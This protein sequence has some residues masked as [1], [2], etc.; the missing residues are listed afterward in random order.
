MGDFDLQRL[1]EGMDL[2]LDDARER[3][4]KLEGRFDSL[5]AHRADVERRLGHVEQAVE[6]IQNEKAS[7]DAVEEYRRDLTVTRRWLAGLAT[8]VVG[9]FIAAVGIALS[10]L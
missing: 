2:K 6:A 8:S 3:L 10:H 9:L 4:I 7:E 1:L 5:D